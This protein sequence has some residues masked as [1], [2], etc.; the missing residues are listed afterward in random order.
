MQVTQFPVPVMPQP[1][2]TIPVRNNLYWSMKI[3]YSV[4][5]MV[6]LTK[7]ISPIIIASDTSHQIPETILAVNYS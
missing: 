2:P 6:Y 7:S 1:A 4:K 3:L 5:H